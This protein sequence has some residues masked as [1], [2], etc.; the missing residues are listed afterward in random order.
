MCPSN[1][2]KFG[3]YLK[4]HIQSPWRLEY[5]QYDLLKMDLKNRQLDHEWNQ[6]DEQAFVQLF[7]NEKNKVVQFI[8]NFSQQLVSR[9]KYSQHLLQNARKNNVAIPQDMRFSQLPSVKDSTADFLNTLDDTLIEILFDIHDFSGF[10][11]LN[12]IG[13]EK[14]LKK[15]KKWTNIDH[16]TG[17]N[18]LD[19]H[20][21]IASLEINHNHSFYKQVSALRYECR[22]DTYKASQLP[23][24][25][26]DIPLVVPERRSKKYWIHQDHISE[27][28]AILSMYSYIIPK[29]AA[30]SSDSSSMSN[31]Y[32]DNGYMD[33]YS[34]RVDEKENTQVVKCKRYG[35][36]SNDSLYYFEDEIHNSFYSGD[37]SS[38]S[39]FK[40]GP[41]D[42]D[43]F[44][45]GKYLVPDIT[46][47]DILDEK[48]A[49]KLKYDNPGALAKATQSGIHSRSLKPLLQCNYNRLT[50]EL[51]NNDDKLVITLDT[52]IVFHQQY[53][54]QDFTAPFTESQG[55]NFPYAI[56]EVKLSTDSRMDDPSHYWLNAFTQKSKLLHEVPKFSKYLQGVYQ[57]FA[58]QESFISQDNVPSWLGFYQK[59]ITASVQYQGLSRSRSLR[60]LLN[61]K[62]V[63]SIIPYTNAQSRAS[64][65]DPSSQKYHDSSV[66]SSRSN[67]EYI[68]LSLNIPSNDANLARSAI[69]V[70]N[71][72]PKIVLDMNEKTEMHSPAMDNSAKSSSSFSR[73]GDW[74]SN[75]ASN[76]SSSG[77]LILDQ[78]G[79]PIIYKNQPQHHHH[80][81]AF[82]YNKTSSK[83]DIETGLKTQKKPKSKKDGKKS[84]KLEPKVFFANERTFIS[85]LQFCALLLTVALNLLNFGDKISRVCGGI[86]LF[87]SMLL[88]LYAL[89]RFQYR[90]WQ[91]R[92]PSQTG[93]FDDLYGPAVLCFL[94]VAALVINF[95]LRFRYLPDSDDTS[96][97]LQTPAN[98]TL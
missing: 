21:D 7:S 42:M 29:S 88:A 38:K 90:A 81:Q 78:D 27:V 97:Y 6:Q 12:N 74:I 34:D 50:F 55:K 60:P 73:Q 22:H 46:D 39:R 24:K 13:F 14:I 18:V 65:Y 32:F 25:Q 58:N 8:H 70:Q 4:E 89:A 49:M 64:S 3:N 68:S 80:G 45:Q 57:V 41:K 67:S 23:C 47:D 53:R 28:T 33:I 82:F 63:R 92:S 2:M 31:L 40:I 16:Q 84:I 9:I 37:I 51:P 95:W 91:L 30:S 87:I 36:F 85:W 17:D 77:N 19:Y 15:H 96:S 83:N 61:G 20:H 69:V 59:G 62:K 66:R 44:C 43:D 86:F 48:E 94:I 72:N 35:S 71:K 56:L 93:R 52:N 10:I 26:H 54:I 98:T 11:R 79:Y 1:I 5:I 76:N 75:T